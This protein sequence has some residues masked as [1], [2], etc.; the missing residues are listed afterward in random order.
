VLA[1]MAM[2][3]RLT[4]EEAMLAADTHSVGKARR[5]DAVA[6]F[7]KWRRTANLSR[8]KAAPAAP[9]QLGGMGIGLKVVPRG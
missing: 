8:Q 3:D 2:L 5:V 1:H 6:T 7:R 9:A 4:A